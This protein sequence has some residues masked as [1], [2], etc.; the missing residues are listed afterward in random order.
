MVETV[1]GP[2]DAALANVAPDPP[3]ND[4]RYNCGVCRHEMTDLQKQISTRHAALLGDTT[5]RDYSGK[6]S[7]FNAF[8]Q[9]ELRELIKGLNLK[10]GM[11]VLDAGCGT[12][13]ALNWLLGEVS[14]MGLVVGVDLAAAH[15]AAA[16]LQAASEIQLYQAN[17]FDDLFDPASFDLVWCVNTIN[18]LTDPVAGVIHLAMLLRHG[19]RAAIGQSSFLPDMYFAWDARLER[20]V[21]D[22]VRRYYQDR[23]ELDEHDLK[24]VR[25]LVGVLRQANLQ[26]VTVRTVMIERMSPLDAATESYL[27][28]VI[29]RGTWGERLRPYLSPADYAELAGLCDSDH[30]NYSLRRPDFHFLQT[31]TLA[32]GEIQ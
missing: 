14:P 26:N 27:K 30:P 4:A 15:V 23:Y 8:A 1:A 13:E 11:Y 9:P 22:A 16:R 20:A 19:G 6:L 25:G 12:G 3:G 24:A 29:F 18:H 2:P 32:T 31:F 17:L 5:A 21:N 10:S 7:K 28:E